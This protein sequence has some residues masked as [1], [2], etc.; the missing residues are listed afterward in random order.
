MFYICKQ[1]A[2]FLFTTFLKGE[3]VEKLNFTSFFNTI[4][5]FCLDLFYSWRKV[6]GRGGNNEV[7]FFSW[8]LHWIKKAKDDFYNFF[9]VKSEEVVFF[10][11][12]F[13][14]HK[15]FMFCMKSEIDMIFMKVLNCLFSRYSIF[16][17]VLNSLVSSR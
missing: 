10:F 14:L 1:P 3:F 11:L 6:V 16:M 15:H 9:Y 4:I 17:K 5:F 2:N 8:P 12:D 13:L 7:K